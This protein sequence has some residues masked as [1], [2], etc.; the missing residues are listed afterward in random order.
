[1]VL[2]SCTPDPSP[3]TDFFA[4]AG[5][6]QSSGTCSLFQVPLQ[7]ST[8]WRYAVRQQGKT[9]AVETIRVSRV[10]GQLAELS[11][12][13]SFK[14]E[15]INWS[16]T[17]DCGSRRIVSQ[18]I[19][20]L[21][22]A[23]W[24]FPGVFPGQVIDEA[25]SGD[26][27]YTMLPRR[28]S[29]S[30]HSLELRYRTLSPTQNA[31]LRIVRETGNGQSAEIDI[32]PTVGTL[33]VRFA[34]QSSIELITE[35]EGKEIE[36]Q[37]N[38]EEAGDEH[39][40][41]LSERL[42]ARLRST[43]QPAITTGNQDYGS[44]CPTGGLASYNGH[45]PELGFDTKTGVVSAGGTF[46]ADNDLTLLHDDRDSEF[47]FY[48]NDPQF[49]ALLQL[50]QSSVA[51]EWESVMLF[52]KHPQWIWDNPDSDPLGPSDYPSGAHV[53]AASNHFLSLRD[54]TY[55]APKAGD[56]V[57]V[58]GSIIVDCGHS[59]V[60]EMHPPVAVAWSHAF[61]P[62]I[63][64]Y[65]VRASAYG[66]YP[67]VDDFRG[68]LG[69]MAPD[70]G[71]FEADFDIPNADSADPGSGPVNE[72]IIPVVDYTYAGY[73]LSDDVHSV[74]STDIIPLWYVDA[75]TPN[76]PMAHLFGGDWNQPL[77]TYFDI[78][79]TQNGSKVHIHA[80]PKPPWSTPTDNPQR[81]ALVGFHFM[82][83]LPVHGS[84]NNVDLNGCV[85]SGNY[86]LPNE[87][88]GQ[89][90]PVNLGGVLNGWFYD[91]HRPMD[92]LTIEIR[93]YADTCDL[94]HTEVLFGTVTTAPP[95]HTFSFQIPTGPNRI[96]VPSSPGTPANEPLDGIVLRTYARDERPE[97]ASTDILTYSLPSTC[98]I[99]PETVSVGGLC[100]N[101]T[102]YSGAG[103][104]FCN[105]P[106]FV[107]EPYCQPGS[108]GQP[109]VPGTPAGL[110]VATGAN[111]VTLSWQAVP[112]TVGYNVFTV[113]GS[114]FNKVGFTLSTTFTL[115]GLPNGNTAL[116]SVSAANSVGEGPRAPAV[117][118]STLHCSQ[119]CAGCCTGEACSPPS[120][121]NGCV[122][123]GQ[124]CGAA[125]PSATDV[126]GANGLCACHQSDASVCFGSLGGN[127]EA[128]R[129]CGNFT[130]ACG[131]TVNCGTCTA[132]SACTG[133]TNAHCVCTPIP[134]ATA[135][136]GKCGTVSDG[137]GG[138]YACTC[139]A[140]LLCQSGTCVASSCGPGLRDCCG[141]GTV[142]RASCTGTG[143]L[144]P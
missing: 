58:R 75:Y 143:T 55:Q 56:Q 4:A 67:H 65:Y 76:H 137:C 66:W 2:A 18:G 109:T 47:D 96:C 11:T 91:R 81:P 122:V 30:P 59:P 129:T 142:C 69:D 93:G 13:L 39:G 74:Q 112:G 19:P 101:G 57:A 86:D 48:P 124:T 97:P 50:G 34:P 131:G 37:L 24:P 102:G 128:N 26:F 61:A 36:E 44:Y 104:T 31:P 71:A 125:C 70:A 120:T 15:R 20:E 29:D 62:G 144:C 22:Y 98:V 51:T 23:F 40:F 135:C 9:P 82:A 114:V 78:N 68:P 141:D 12:T 119:V 3:R 54:I 118:G 5:V 127:L 85:G 113:S 107:L 92:P 35:E 133:G 106:A 49:A 43:A 140:G 100:P 79:V 63:A 130:N 7:P 45:W 99:S 42:A 123:N 88:I 73:D 17:I 138:S 16:T 53:Y 32:E 64:D 95:N 90:E 28:V 6:G 1:M 110:V 27:S 116:Y 132:P 136:A 46:L 21:A 52:P 60:I 115:G 25:G 41:S 126:C 14:E 108:S 83:C 10:D 87:Y 94:G 139:G 134:Q 33:A 121:S 117:S 111:Q 84:P 105:Y 89:V 72:T 80:K 38:L 77:S 8:E 103:Y